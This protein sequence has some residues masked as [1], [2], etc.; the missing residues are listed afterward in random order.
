MIL[1]HAF[2]L[3]IAG[4]GLASNVD[5]DAPYDNHNIMMGYYGLL[6]EYIFRAQKLINM[7]VAALIGGGGIRVQ[8]P[9]VTYMDHDMDTFFVVE[10]ELTLYLN[11]VKYF[12]IGLGAG[13]RFTR[14]VDRKE[15]SDSEIGGFTANLTLQFGVF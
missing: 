8:D 9:S 14:G 2:S 5:A 1:N 6:P 7:S 15:L 13:Y 10:P 3:G 4:Y 12:R 11:V